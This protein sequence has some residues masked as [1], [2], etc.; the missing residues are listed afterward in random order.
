MLL[1]GLRADARMADLNLRHGTLMAGSLRRTQEAQ[2]QS[3]CN[4]EMLSTEYRFRW[5]DEEV[6]NCACPTNEGNSQRGIARCT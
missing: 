5:R 1:V 2:F 4:N 3:D 6:Q